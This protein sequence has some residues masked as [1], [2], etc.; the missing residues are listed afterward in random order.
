MPAGRRYA[1]LIRERNQRLAEIGSVLGGRYRLV[2]LLGQGGMAT[3]YR[4]TDSQLGRDVAVKILRPEYG[5]DPDFV[6]RFRAEAQAV[7]SLSHPNVVQ[8]HDFGMDPVG[9][10]IVMGYVD[11]EDLAT[12]LRR[13][14]PLQPRQAARIVAESARALA[15]AHSRGIIH[16]D[17]K[18]GNIMLAQDGR[19]QMTDFG[20]ARAISDAQMTLPGTTLGSVHYFSPEQARGE[21]ATERS[22]IYSLGIVLFELLTG[23]RPFE[24]DS[25]ASIAMAR[26]SGPAPMPSN[27]R[28]GIPLELEA[29]D[30]KALALDPA[31][32]F[33]SAN[34]MADAIEHWLAGRSAGVG[35]AVAVP[36]PG[37]SVAGLA[38]GSGLAA[39]AGLAAGT[40]LGAGLAAGGAIDS[41]T[42]AAGVARSNAGA[43]LPYPPDAYAN[44]APP[45][46]VPPG[47]PVSRYD[48]IDDEPGPGGTSPWAWVA[49]LL[50]LL[51]LVVAGFLI[52]KLVTGTSKP[53]SQIVVPNFV[54][55]LLTDA[56]TTATNN[57]LVL[58]T[59]AFIKSNDQPEGTIVQQDPAA[60]T[61]VA[62]GST[63]SVTVS[64]GK[65]LVTVPVLSGLTLSAAIQALATAQLIPGVATTAADPL[66][67]AGSI[68]STS[69][70]AGVQVASGTPID[71]VVSSGPA[72]SPTPT[73]TPT[74]TPA[75]TPT[76]T[77]VPTPPPTPTPTPKVTPPPTPDPSASAAASA[78]ASASASAAAGP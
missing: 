17:V 19:V 14:G 66:I 67:P 36:A 24:G 22:D 7:A 9:P 42:V 29:I 73:P 4:A 57:N 64:T 72:A 33:V 63:I 68:I 25:A 51:I 40:G 10:Y 18:P 1:H 44:A 59:T 74:P 65:A 48:S 37:P 21:P 5:R 76:P 60:S 61:T 62:A 46:R 8:V 71:Y 58:V 32:R 16:R 69:P 41:G 49:G 15:A 35:G 45:S 27:F 3:I 47:P 43:G 31:D 75:P 55:T 53:A 56:K 78:A 77:P 50:G 20:I 70:A 6:A 54:G 12:L 11:G 26:L 13:T 38:A 52:F 39:G 30:R 34:A 23:R 2:E 28:A